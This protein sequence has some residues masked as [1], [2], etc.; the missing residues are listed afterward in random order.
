MPLKLI[1]GPPNSGRRGLVLRAF[2][3]ASEREPLL[4]VPTADDAFDVER[5]LCAAGA[6]G[7]TVLGGTVLTF[8]GLA[9]E[10]ATACGRPPAPTLSGAQRLR[11]IAV[12]LERRR[13]GLGPL[14]RSAGREGFAGSLSA[15]LDELQS[16]GLTP[17][18]V[19]A[20]AATLD[21]SA[22][23]ADLASLF[24]AY[25]KVRA[26]VG[27]GDAHAVAAEAIAA[28]R[29]RPEAWE[30]P[31]FVYGIDD[32][33]GNQLEL[34]AALAAASE[35]ALA[36]S[37]ERREVFAGRTRLLE[38]LR[39]RVDVAEEETT[40]AQS[41]HT[42][43][44]ILFHLERNLGEPGPAARGG[45]EGEGEGE[46]V[47]LLRSA[48]PRGEA[49]AVGAAFARLLHDGAD[50][51]EIAIVLRDPA[52]RGPLI[53]RAL[54]SYGIP[55][56]LEAEVP[57]ATTGVGGALIALLEAEH[58]S[59]RAGDVLRWLRGPSGARPHSVDWLERAVRRERA[60]TAA[61]ALALWSERSDLPRDLT[62]LR[63][64][65]PGS[66]LEELGATVTRMAAR[67]VEGEGDGRPP[68]PGARAE[69]RV[70]AEIAG[71]LAELADLGP[72][73]PSPAELIP[74]LREMRFRLWSGP[75]GG[76][77]RIA[78]PRRLR[79]LR[80]DH[81]LVGSLQDGEFPRR[82]GGDPFLSDALRESLGLEPR[83]EEDVEERYLFYSSISLARR[84]LTLSYRE[85]DDA[86]AAEA[87][88]PLIDDVLA[89]LEPEAVAEG[90]RGLAEVAF[91][92]GE[93][94]SL[95]ELARSLAAAGA[96]PDRSGLLEAAGPD[97][98]SREGIEARLRAAAAAERAS[99]AP[100]PLRNPAVLER[101]GAR[102][103][104]GGTTLERF[105][106]CSYIWFAEHELR[107]LPLD[108]VPDALV[109][110]G[111]VHNALDRLFGERPGGGSRPRPETVAAWK[112]RSAELVAELAAERGLG[113]SAQERAIKRGAERLLARFLD[114]EAE[115]ESAFEPVLL[116]AGFG[117]GEGNDRP[118]LEVDDWL[119]HGAIDR[120]DQAPDGRALIHDYKVAGRVTPV[121]KFEEEA[122]LQLP[123]YALAAEEQW[124]LEPVAALYHPLRGTRERA[125]RGLVLAEDRDDL[126]SYPL[127][128]TDVLDRERFEAEIEGARA[129]ASRIVARMRSGQI[130]RDPGPREGLRNHDVCPRYCAL[131]P[132]CRRDRT[133][134]VDEEREPEEW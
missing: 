42:E 110:G 81:V 127:V 82:G 45:G 92:A 48:G 132:I 83:R 19:E 27:R 7:G 74:F 111:L 68:G 102:R 29:A 73:A 12:A 117:E 47:T 49:E 85:S 58:G 131:A 69:L 1:Q 60:R 99:R 118:A 80:F 101:L 95:E 21:R 23:L 15:L 109:Q 61:E 10:V 113:T 128:K 72:L 18:D 129:R 3:A 8:R 96:G 31:V 130:T 120:V 84:S 108:P 91:A 53:S 40:G 41:T 70:A 62:R 114:E 17:A 97:A 57:V 116:E 9:A 78:D 119:L 5:E 24:A 66:W 2:R 32:L 125:P 43:N 94:P 122:K 112:S 121:A 28:L 25:E 100:G 46:G 30:R 77:V 115:R 20:G 52:R 6:Q 79:A 88:S 35:V 50:P 65:G 55:T 133:P 67:F 51:G 71:S 4:V 34:L 37:F 59:G 89:L 90:G 13:G 87:R 63:E 76:R 14:R 103:L 104:F 98:G 107:P 26:E 64:A 54:E 39:D 134:V 44:P 93:A 75:V 22:Y 33:T 106:V 123:L 126:G 36:I 38:R 86:G 105:D 16:A 124:G 56:A 11:A